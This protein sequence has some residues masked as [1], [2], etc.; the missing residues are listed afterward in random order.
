MVYEDGYLYEGTGLYG[1]SALI[2]RDFKT[3]KI[4]KMIRLPDRYFG[5]GVALVGDHV[6][7][8][9][10]REHTGFVYDKETFRELRQFSYNMEGWGLTYDGTRLILSDGSDT[11]YF[12]DPNTFSTETQN[13][14][15]VQ[16]RDQGRPIHYINE[17]E[18]IDGL[19]YANILGANYIAIISPQTGAV[20]GWINLTGLYTPA[21]SDEGNHVL[22]GIAYLPQSK[23]LLVTGKCWTRLFEI[24]L[25]PLADQ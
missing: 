9:T 14:A 15:S 4:V 7:Q 23:H 5:E 2:K 11:L 20:T 19:I 21:P 13:P 16:V 25:V 17:L 10:W 3:W 22:N 12:L 24:E 1:Q 6:I 8:L 18:Y